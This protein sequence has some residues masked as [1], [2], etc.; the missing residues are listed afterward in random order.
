MN[1]LTSRIVKLEDRVS[2]YSDRPII[3]H[4]EAE[5]LEAKKTHHGIIIFDNIP[6]D[7]SP[8]EMNRKNEER[9]AL[10]ELPEYI[11][12]EDPKYSLS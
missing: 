6:D 10:M 1:N 8:E 7:D 11:R 4:T 3:V 12:P 5:L 9:V 2:S